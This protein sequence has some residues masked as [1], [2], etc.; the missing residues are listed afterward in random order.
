MQ[1][2]CLSKASGRRWRVPGSPHASTRRW[3]ESRGGHAPVTPLWDGGLRISPP[4]RTVSTAR[5]FPATKTLSRLSLWSVRAHTHHNTTRTMSGTHSLTQVSAPHAVHSTRARVT[6]HY[7]CVCAAA[8]VFR[9]RGSRVGQ[10]FCAHSFLRRASVRY[11]WVTASP[12][13]C[14]YLRTYF[15]ALLDTDTSSV[16]FSV[17]LNDTVSEWHYS[18]AAT[19]SFLRSLFRPPR[20]SRVFVQLKGYGTMSTSCRRAQ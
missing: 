16:D 1:S 10:D 9:V 8:L 18:I 15:F 4:E 2:S 14:S 20:W 7:N 13:S 19:T 6:R 5:K 3:S 12:V 17:S 11:V